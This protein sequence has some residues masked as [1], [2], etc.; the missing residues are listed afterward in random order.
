MHIY[1]GCIASI[2]IDTDTQT[3][4]CAWTPMQSQMHWYRSV[5]DF[6]LKDALCNFFSHLV[7]KFYIALKRIYAL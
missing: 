1:P 6:D 5:L 4:I 7:V 2:C 3:Y